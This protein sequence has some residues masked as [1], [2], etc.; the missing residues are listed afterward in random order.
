[1]IIY[2]DLQ[3]HTKK[4]GALFVQNNYPFNNVPYGP[5]LPVRE[6]VGAIIRNRYPRWI[7]GT[8]KDI[9]VS[10][11]LVEEFGERIPVLQCDGL[12]FEAP[13]DKDELEAWI[14]SLPRF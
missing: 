1:M 7:K 14:S 9:S 10:A 3:C 13:F 8:T 11:E 4:V 12:L 5:L 2:F 6:S